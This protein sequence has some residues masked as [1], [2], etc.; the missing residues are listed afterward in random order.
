MARRGFVGVKMSDEGRDAIQAIADAE[1]G[2]N[3]SEAIRDLLAD[4]LAQRRRRKQAGAK[5]NDQ[6]EPAE[7][8]S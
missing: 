5:V 1:H 4:A 7:K 6:A 2:G 8:K 3:L